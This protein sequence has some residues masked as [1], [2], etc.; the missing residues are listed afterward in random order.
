MRI[1]VLCPVHRRPDLIL[2]QIKNYLTFGGEEFLHILHPSQEGRSKFSGIGDELSNLADVHLCDE[3]WSTSWSCAMAAYLSCTK[4][5]ESF[6]DFDYVYLHTDADLLIKKG[7]PQWI[8]THEMGFKANKYYANSAWIHSGSLNS[9]SAYLNLREYLGIKDDD[10]LLGR[11]EGAFYKREIWSE[12]V[13]IL[14]KFFPREYFSSTNKLWPIE[15]SV[16]PTVAKHIT[17]D[18]PAS[19]NLIYTKEVMFPGGRENDQNC[20]TVEDINDLRL[21]AESSFFGAKWFSQK[22]DDSA[23]GFLKSL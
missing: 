6:D 11:Q 5:L 14:K 13:E 10:V 15:E 9:D 7:L 4:K 19:S 8:K 16:I 23:R 2:E 18:F 1:A 20:L 3:S 22:I 21:N 12:I 17:R